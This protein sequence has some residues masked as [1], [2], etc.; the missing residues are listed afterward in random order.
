MSVILRQNVIRGV[1]LRCF[2]S[3]NQTEAK[4]ALALWK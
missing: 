2:Y 1:Q 3:V 4:V